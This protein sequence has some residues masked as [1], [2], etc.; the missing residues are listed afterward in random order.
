M[1]RRRRRS[2]G[3]HRWARNDGDCRLGRLNARSRRALAFVR[4]CSSATANTAAGGGVVKLAHVVLKRAQVGGKPPGA[5]AQALHQRTHLLVHGLDLLEQRGGGLRDRL[6]VRLRLRDGI[7]AGALGVAVGLLAGAGSS[8][9]G[10]LLDVGGGGLGG[11]EDALHLTAG[12]GAEGFAAALV[13]GAFEL[14][15]LGGEGTQVGVHGGRLI[16]TAA[17][18]KVAP[19]DAL[20]VE[21][22]LKRSLANGQEG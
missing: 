22:H 7:A 18:G 13:E 10:L 9:G 2:A 17:D 19:F 3:F 20:A 15:H 16:P 5:G 8:L 1:M 11:L 6:H 21:V 14:L 4:Q 12:G